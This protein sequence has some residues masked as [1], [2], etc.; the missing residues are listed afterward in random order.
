MTCIVAL[1]DANQTAYVAADSARTTDGGMSTI[2]AGRKL[3]T[4]GAYLIGV[5]GSIRIEELIHHVLIPPPPP[6]Y[7]TESFMV[8]AFV[9]QLRTCLHENQATLPRRENWTELVD[10]CFLVAVNGLVFEIAADLQVVQL[11]CGIYGIG[12]GGQ[13]AIGALYATDPQLTPQARLQTALNAA[14]EFDAA[15]RPPFFLGVSTVHPPEISPLGQ[16]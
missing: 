9:P 15:V 1:T 8:R 12:S 10:A 6:P 7:P 4:N 14:A 3:F 11:D 5:A 16:I 13:L 2:R